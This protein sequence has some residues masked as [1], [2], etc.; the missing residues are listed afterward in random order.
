MIPTSQIQAFSS[1]LS[2]LAGTLYDALVK[3]SPVAIKRLEH[4]QQ[5]IYLNKRE[6]IELSHDDPNILAHELGHHD[7]DET[8]F[9]RFIQDPKIRGLSGLLGYVAP[10]LLAASKH[11]SPGLAAAMPLLANSPILLGEAMA[12][13]KG[14]KRMRDAGATPEEMSNYRKKM[15]SAGLSYTVAPAAHGVLSGAIAAV[16]RRSK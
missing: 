15:L 1:E 8:A 6:G 11:V 16:A 13:A 14:A 7:V 5:G 2:K 12:S 3:S 10:P 9:G 4:A